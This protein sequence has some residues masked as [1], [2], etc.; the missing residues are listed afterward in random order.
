MN[1]SENSLSPTMR[2][3]QTP[4]SL[5]KMCVSYRDQSVRIKSS[6]NIQ[7]TVLE[8]VLRLCVHVNNRVSVK[9]NKQKAPR[10]SN[11]VD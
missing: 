5:F 2:H 8:Q 11:P 7:A 6:L 9:Q 10:T 4:A 3:S 1:V